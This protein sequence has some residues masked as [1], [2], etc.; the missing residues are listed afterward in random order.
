MITLFNVNYLF[1]IIFVLY[2]YIIVIMAGTKKLSGS[3]N[4]K[5]T[6]LKHKKQLSVQLL[7]KDTA[8]VLLHW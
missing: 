5:K 2:F 8:F 7:A 6:L 3:H 4:R 1:L